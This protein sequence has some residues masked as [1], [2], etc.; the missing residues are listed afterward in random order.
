MSIL[1]G[2]VLD[3]SPC[4]HL[5][6]GRAGVTQPRSGC[7]VT[8]ITVNI[9]SPLPTASAQCKDGGWQAFGVFKN[10]GDCVSFVASKGKNQPG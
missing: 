10:Q 8:S 4:H 7:P 5:D 9:T 6:G 2:V 3:G 1:N